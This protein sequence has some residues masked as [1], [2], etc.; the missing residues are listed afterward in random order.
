MGG[1]D[2][3][4]LG[5]TLWAASARPLPGLSPLKDTTRADV[6]VVGGGILGLSLALHLAERGIETVVLEAREPGAGAS[7]RSTGFIVPSLYASLDQATVENVMG[8][9][10]AARFLDFVGRSAEPVFDLV[11]RHDL[12]ARAERTAWIHPASTQAWAERLRS[13]RLEWEGLGKTVQWLDA[14]ETAAR[15]GVP[16]YHGALLDE[17]G[18]QLNPL[19]YVRE[20]TRA[21]L[22]RGVRVHGQSPVTSLQ[23]E[24]EAWALTTP[25]GAVRADR[26]VLTTNALVGNL[27]PA[28]ARNLM[29]VTAFQIATS[30]LAP[31]VRARLLPERWCLSDTRRH[32]FALRWDADG[33]LV[34]GGLVM[35]GP[36]RM[37]RARRGFVQRLKRLVPDLGAIKAAYAWRGTIAATPLR[38]PLYLDLASGLRAIVACNGRGIALTTA[39]GGAL[40]RQLSGE[41]GD[42]EFPLPLRS[43]T[44]YPARFLGPAAPSLWLIKSAL[45]ERFD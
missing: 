36:R 20:L 42:D 45:M 3:G 14:D 24:G 35:G 2:Q 7:G 4:A 26:V 30:P 39:L 40:A 44:N 29:P 32:P 11:A 5:D 43:P 38:L 15:T 28:L 41:I 33:C 23:R 13:R 34:T 37:E 9:A 6:A 25:T 21:V 1:Q 8:A 19:A 27:W 16:G 12:D 31:E 18:G 22:S 17:S 10:P